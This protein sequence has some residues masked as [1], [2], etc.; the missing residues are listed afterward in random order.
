[1]SPE[2]SLEPTRIVKK[3]F[4]KKGFPKTVNGFQPV[5]IFANSFI[6][7]VPLLN[8]SLKSIVNR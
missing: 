1:M 7:D 6:L 3:V 8:T 4:R 2:A 5:T